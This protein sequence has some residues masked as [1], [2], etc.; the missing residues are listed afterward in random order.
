MSA[1]VGSIGSKY[2][3]IYNLEKENNYQRFS[4]KN[5]PEHFKLVK[6]WLPKIGVITTE[7]VI[8][9]EQSFDLRIGERLVGKLRLN[10]SKQ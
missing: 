3:Q 7:I 9:E 1:W 8:G 4:M 2:N 10:R 5:Y 6:I